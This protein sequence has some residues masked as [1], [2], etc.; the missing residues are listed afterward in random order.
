[1]R[2]TP[3]ATARRRLGAGLGPRDAKKRFGQHFLER[4]W[5]DKLI[6]VIGPRETDTFLEIGPGHG[7]L[8]HPLAAAALHVLAFEI[9]RDLVHTLRQASPPNLVIVEGDFLATS[10][11]DVREAI[12]QAGAAQPEELVLR[13]AGNLPYNVASPIL[14]KLI[15][16]YR[17]GVRLQEATVMLQREVAERL[18]AAP[19]S[20]DYGVLSVLIRQAAD[21]ER[22]LTLPPG[23]FRPPPKVDSAVV[24]LRFHPDQPAARN[25]EAFEAL[26]QAVFTRRRKTL[27]NALLAYR[28][29]G[30]ADIQRA[31]AKIGMDGVRRPESL[32]VAEFAR[33]SDAFDDDPGAPVERTRAVL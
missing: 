28:P 31:L 7:A 21:V 23:A 19:G 14:F 11:E 3:S 16:L 6:R 9:D 4:T 18:V 13:V 20:R 27:A 10:P 5:V 26:V 32:N 12:R 22:L 24:R 8:T 15:A 1:V 25:P 17:A 29:D 33:L 2:D 30:K